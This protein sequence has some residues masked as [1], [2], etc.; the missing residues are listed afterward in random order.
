MLTEK[1][2][3]QRIKEL[4]LQADIYRAHIQSLSFVVEG[5]RQFLKKSNLNLD[6]H[7]H[8]RT[9]D[10]KLTTLEKNDA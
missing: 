8:L 2:M 5:Y 6:P 4:E 10:G 3:A 7:E 9:Y 1:Q